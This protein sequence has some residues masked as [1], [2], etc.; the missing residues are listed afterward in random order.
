LRDL[1]GQ[2][3][4]EGASTR[5]LVYC[6]TLIRAGVKTDTAIRTALIEPLTDDPDV[7]A[8]LLRVADIALG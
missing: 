7:R 6:A 3:L 2:D 8:A 4:E 5:L 1:K